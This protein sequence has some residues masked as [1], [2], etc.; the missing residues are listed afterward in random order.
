MH[1]YW[2]QW[3]MEGIALERPASE[4]LCGTTEKEYNCIQCMALVHHTASA[5]EIQIAI[6][7]TV[8]VLSGPVAVEPRAKTF[9]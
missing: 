3:S 5:A 8:T 4:W 7:T 2:Q 1:D 6:G 9:R